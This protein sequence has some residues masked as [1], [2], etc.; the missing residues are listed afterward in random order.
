MSSRFTSTVVI[1][2]I[3]NTSKEAPS[4]RDSSIKGMLVIDV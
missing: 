2:A 3:N 1:N 4:A